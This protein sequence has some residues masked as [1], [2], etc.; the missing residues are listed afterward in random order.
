MKHQICLCILHTYQ[1]FGTR[2]ADR[3]NKG[4]DG[5]LGELV[6]HMHMRYPVHLITLSDGFGGKVDGRTS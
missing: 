1:N 4:I 2:R 5:V 3:T 6:I